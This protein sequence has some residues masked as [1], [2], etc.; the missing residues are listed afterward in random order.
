MNFHHGSFV[1][2]EQDDPTPH[3]KK[4]VIFFF[5]VMN[6]KLNLQLLTSLQTLIKL[7]ECEVY[8]LIIEMRNIINMFIID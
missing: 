2:D 5:K 1:F 3:Y 4:D 6:D 7:L 8:F